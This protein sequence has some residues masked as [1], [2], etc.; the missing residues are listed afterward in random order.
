MARQR[1]QRCSIE[2]L[3][4]QRW[5]LSD[6]TSLT[7]GDSTGEIATTSPAY[8]LA[9][10]STSALITIR[11]EAR[12]IGSLEACSSIVNLLLE[13]AAILH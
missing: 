9:C 12:D 8:S 6:L 13:N 5:G 1:R 11:R 7:D 4:E 2:A 3:S 10:F